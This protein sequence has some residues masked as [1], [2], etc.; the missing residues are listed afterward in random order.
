VH[1]FEL[2]SALS[3]YLVACHCRHCFAP[4]QAVRAMERSWLERTRFPTDPDAFLEQWRA[5]HGATPDMPKGKGSC[6]AR[7]QEI[8]Y[9]RAIRLETIP[10]GMV[11]HVWIEQTTCRLQGGCSTTDLMRHRPTARHR[12]SVPARAPGQFLHGFLSELRPATSPAELLLLARP[13][14]LAFPLITCRA[15]N[16][17]RLVSASTTNGPNGSPQT[18]R[19]QSMQR[20]PKN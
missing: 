2:T 5:L 14:A 10:E 3:R 7:N 12:F 8:C 19:R 13:R 1:C 18:N 16:S 17:P 15:A 20:E 9:G 11:P 4:S 6:R